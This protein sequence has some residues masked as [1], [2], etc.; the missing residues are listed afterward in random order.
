MK[1]LEKIQFVR[2]RPRNGRDY[3]LNLSE[4]ILKSFPNN[5]LLIKMEK[6]KNK[7]KDLRI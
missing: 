5:N 4:M 3:Y 1:K 6:G 7:M 2:K